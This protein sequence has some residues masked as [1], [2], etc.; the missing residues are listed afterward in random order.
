M[1]IAANDFTIEIENVNKDFFT[2]ENG[3]KLFLDKRF[4]HD[5]CY[6]NICK[7]IGVPINNDTDLKVGDKVLIET[8]LFMDNEYEKQGKQFNRFFIDKNIYKCAKDLILLVEH[9]NEWICFDDNV[10]LEEIVIKK[11]ST[12]L[13]QHSTA[14]TKYKVVYNSE[15][16][17]KET[18]VLCNANYTMDIYINDKKYLLTKT[19]NIPAIYE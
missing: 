15:L 7:I 9:N 4:S 14:E 19:F 6:H 3:L 10:V 8:T 18:Y 1:V 16:I 13:I 5:K 11:E 17:A 12:G 2:T